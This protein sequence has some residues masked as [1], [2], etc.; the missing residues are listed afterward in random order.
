M[1]VLFRVKR[2]N[3]SL[4]LEDLVELFRV[5]AR[6]RRLG[7]QLERNAIRAISIVAVSDING[8]SA[9]V[10]FGALCVESNGHNRRTAW[11]N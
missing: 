10:E 7:S 11:G 6:D 1:G 8:Q 3:H 4:F 2:R 9:I 5:D